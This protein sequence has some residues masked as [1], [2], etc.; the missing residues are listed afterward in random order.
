MFFPPYQ[1]GIEG[2]SA[3]R[4]VL[5]QSLFGLSSHNESLT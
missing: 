1:G 4:K 2:G 3:R 5:T